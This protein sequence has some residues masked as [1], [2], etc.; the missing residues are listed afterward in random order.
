[1]SLAGDIDTIDNISGAI[2]GGKLR[3]SADSSAVELSFSQDTSGVLAALGINSFFTGTNART[4]ALNTTIKDRPALLAA[5]RNGE[6]GDNQ[7]ALAIA[8]LESVALG[9]LDGATLTARYESMVNGVAVS[10]ATAAT[11]AEASVVVR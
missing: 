5:A 6:K 8:G 11:N 2:A 7:T 3:I 10:A 4:I 1:N 9:S